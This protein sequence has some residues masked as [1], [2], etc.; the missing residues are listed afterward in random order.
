[1]WKQGQKLQIDMGK[2]IETKIKETMR[3]NVKANM[4][5]KRLD[6]EIVEESD[7]EVQQSRDNGE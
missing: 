1:M 2:E 3:K 4:R 6:M 7:G 5:R